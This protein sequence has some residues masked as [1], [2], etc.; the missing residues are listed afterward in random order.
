MKRSTLGS[1]IFAIFAASACGGSPPLPVPEPR[2]ETAVLREDAARLLELLNV[3]GVLGQ[4]APAFSRQAAIL[5]G[6]PTDAE[7]E[8]LIPA[9]VD[10]FAY[11]SLYADVISYMAT[12]ADTAV[13]DQ[14][15][16]WMEGGA[17]AAVR[18]I[19]E[20]YEPAQT[21]QEYANE[22]TDEPPSEARI[23]L[24]SEWA[25]AR[26]EGSFFVLLQEALREAAY[27]V[28]DVMRPGTPSF[29]PLSGEELEMAQVNSHGATVIRLL[30]GYAP[31][32]DQL[33]RR[34]T[35]E[36]RTDSGRWLTETYA[37]AVANAIRAAGERVAQHLS[38][39]AGG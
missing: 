38:E 1:L 4:R 32:P 16:E 20:E 15:L 7:L 28:H 18:R 34:S 6:D 33:I 14:A 3:E 5:I 17:T 9:V 29:E 25:E 26:G 39:G 22:M 35:T 2:D 19:G 37:L 21:L 27:R 30:H 36:Y 8:Q 12:E 10:A 24:I 13:L 23:H 31:A 11:E